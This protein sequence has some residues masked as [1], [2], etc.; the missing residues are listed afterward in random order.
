MTLLLPEEDLGI[1]F[2]MT[3]KWVVEK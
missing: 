2:I 3:L 1:Y